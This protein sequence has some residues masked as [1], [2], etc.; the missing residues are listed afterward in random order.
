MNVFP[1]E[2]T[3]R[4]DAIFAEL[5]RTY[6]KNIFPI[7]GPYLPILGPYMHVDVYINQYYKWNVSLIKSMLYTEQVINWNIMDPVDYKI[8]GECTWETKILPLQR[9]LVPK[10]NTMSAR[11]FGI[12]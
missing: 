11:I 1:E 12:E 7:A 3:I 6:D 2:T 8:A 9:Q 5:V 10:L 4:D